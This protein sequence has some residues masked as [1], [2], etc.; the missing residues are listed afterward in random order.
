VVV[1]IAI[2]LAALTGWT[3]TIVSSL[4]PL[5]VLVTPP[6]RWCTSTPA[7]SIDPPARIWPCTRTGTG[8][9]VSAQH[10]LDFR[11]RDRLR[12]A[13]GIHIRPVREMGCGPQRAWWWPGLASFTLFPALQQLLR[14]PTQ[15]EIAA[16]GRWTRP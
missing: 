10:G 3:H 9:Q 4:V 2:G 11:N 12:R 5:T 8:Q 6:L 15:S 14:T 13:G 1:S 16:A 7:T